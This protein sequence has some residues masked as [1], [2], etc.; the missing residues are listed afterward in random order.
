[1]ANALQI[2]DIIFTVLQHLEPLQLL[3]VTRV[4]KLWRR[5]IDDRFWKVMRSLVCLRSVIGRYLRQLPSV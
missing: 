5:T 4:S 3:K 2:P 1:M